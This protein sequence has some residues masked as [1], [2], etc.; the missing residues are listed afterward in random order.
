MIFMCIRAFIV[1]FGLNC[2]W[3]WEKYLLKRIG[4]GSDGITFVNGMKYHIWV[5]P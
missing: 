2:G 3:E 5:I 4:M 1:Y